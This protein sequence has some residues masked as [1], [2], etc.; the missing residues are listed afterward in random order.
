[1]IHER[2]VSAD[3]A[4]LRLKLRHAPAAWR[5]AVDDARLRRGLEP[6]GAAKAP[7]SVPAKP[8]P[9]R[10]SAGTLAIAVCPGTSLPTRGAGDQ[11]LLPEHVAPG[12]WEGFLADVRAGKT[13]VEFQDR[14]HGTCLATTRDNSLRFSIHERRGLLAEADVGNSSLER[15]II[16]LVSDMPWGCA[17]SPMLIAEDFSHARRGGDLC[18]IIRKARVHHVALL[19]PASGDKPAFGDARAYA[20]AAGDTGLRAAWDRLLKG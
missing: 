3:V 9:P 15:L 4:S 18:R 5:M 2:A 7:G 16:S 13:V 6:L 17:V 14:H 19:L 11:T 20:A 1:M 10:A 12:A 8:A